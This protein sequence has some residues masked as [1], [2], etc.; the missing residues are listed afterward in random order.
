V[1]EIST[2]H[3]NK[4]EISGVSPNRFDRIQDRS[5]WQI[6]GGLLAALWIGG[7][8]RGDLEPSGGFNKWAVKMSAS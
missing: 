8:D 6:P 3:H 1:G 7:Y 2:G 4:I 5:R